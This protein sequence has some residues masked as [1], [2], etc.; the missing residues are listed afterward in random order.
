MLTI[1]NAQL[2]DL[3][4]FAVDR[5]VDQVTLHVAA[6]FPRHYRSLGEDGVREFVQRF[7]IF[8]GVSYG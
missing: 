4:R 6:E 3:R 5:F 8:V 7:I 2:E 1:R